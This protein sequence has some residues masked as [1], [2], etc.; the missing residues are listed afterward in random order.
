MND[1]AKSVPRE[2][3]WFPFRLRLSGAAI[4]NA[5]DLKSS[6]SIAVIGCLVL[7]ATVLVWPETLFI[8]LGTLVSE[9]LTCVGTGLLI[10]AGTVSWLPGLAGCFIGVYVGDLAIWLI[11][12][13]YG[14]KVLD[15]KWFRK[16]TG[17]QQLESCRHWFENYGMLAVLISRFL[18]GIRVPLYLAIGMLEGRSVRFP[19]WSLVAVVLWIPLLVGFS[20]WI[21]EAFLP[22]VHSTLGPVALVVLG[23]ISIAR[24]D[25]VVARISQ[26]T[27]PMLDR[28]RRWE[29]WPAWLFYLPM[30]PWIAWLMVRYRSVTV[31][32]AANPGIPHGGVVGESKYEILSKLPSQWRTPS[33]LL[34]S[35]AISNRLAKFDKICRDHQWS[36][37]LVLKPDVGQR[38]DGVKIVHNEQDVARYLAERTSPIIVQTYHPGPFEAGVFYVR[39]PGDACGRIFSITDKRFPI[40]S[41]DG[42]STIRELI[43]AH[44]RYRFQKQVFFKR[45]ASNLTQVLQSG[46]KFQLSHAG[47]HCQGTL[48]LD[49]S[50]L[51]TTELENRFDE[52][53]R[54]FKGFF[55][56]RFDVRYRSVEGF[57]AGEDLSIVELNG[58]TSE[59]TNLY[60][61]KHSL[62]Q[63]Y[64]ILA[65]QWSLL[66]RIGDLNRRHG[67]KPTAFITLC[68]LI[69]M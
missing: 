29:F 68:R 32:T 57:L 59:S 37:P 43:L 4:L 16:R 53:A 33:A 63:A 3:L 14:K 34:E 27:V 41:G 20:F 19:I 2:Q 6:R 10:H 47:N 1:V 49:G 39:I 66:F 31:W 64:S 25:R 30:V 21:G 8:V 56:G 54:Q 23:I 50:H 42:N 52:I 40:V 5:I 67:Y 7:I 13:T 44:H 15:W 55:F 38:G 61:P 26:W 22:P 51:I 46:E 36:F 9:D 35:D 48:F 24:S 45:H 65:E 62:W 11:G 28:C 69:A 12:R 58:V 17:L 60:D 18:P